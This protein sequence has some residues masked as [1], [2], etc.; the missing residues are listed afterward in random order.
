VIAISSGEIRAGRGPA[1][2]ADTP[3]GPAD[4]VKRA[5]TIA[6]VMCIYTNQNHV[7]ETL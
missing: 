5:L 7:I 2:L 3:L 4:I 6:G 1:L